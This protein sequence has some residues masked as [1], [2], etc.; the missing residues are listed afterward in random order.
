MLVAAAQLTAGPDPK[1]NLGKATRA[2][3][4]AAGRGARLVVFP[5]LF[6]AWVPNYKEPGAFQAVAQPLD[7]PFVQ[8]LADAARALDLWIVAGVIEKIA[9][10]EK[11]AHNTTVILNDQGELAGLYRK[12]HLFDAFG[13]QES[14]VIAPGD[15]LFKPIH[16]PMGLTGVF[17]C[18]ELRFPEVARY[19]AVNGA[20]VLIVPSAWFSGPM[21]EQHWRYLAVARAIEN[22][23]YVIAANQVGPNF[24][25]RSLIVDPMGVVLAEGTEIEGLIHADVDPERVAAIRNRI[26]SL[27]QRRTDLGA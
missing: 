23:A 4:Q 14:R 10:S 6:M 12:T 26:P 25:G 18:Y 21:K 22:T 17:V 11:R 5:E 24:L 16:T 7:G 27:S 2:A 13:Y 1:D 3:A 9:D 8:G 19:Q 15:L 20:E